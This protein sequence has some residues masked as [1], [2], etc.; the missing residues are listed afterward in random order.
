MI[1]K[2]TLNKILDGKYPKDRM[3]FPFC[4]VHDCEKSIINDSVS[5]QW[6][7]ITGLNDKSVLRIDNREAKRTRE[8]FEM[9]EALTIKGRP[10]IYDSANRDF[11]KKYKGADMDFK[12]N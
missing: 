6:K 11:L 4:L 3:P 1:S 5:F 10:V 9:E 12:E 8:L 2:S 7:L